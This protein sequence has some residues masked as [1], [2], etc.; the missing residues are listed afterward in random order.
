MNFYEYWDSL[1]KES[2]VGFIKD[3]R[4]RT[5]PVRLSDRELARHFWE[6]ALEQSKEDLCGSSS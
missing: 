3:S 2:A 1:F 5:T 4:G 6:K